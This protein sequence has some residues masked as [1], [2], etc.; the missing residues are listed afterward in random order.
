MMKEVDIFQMALGLTPPWEVASCEFSAE[1]KRLDI[2]L[3]FPRGSVFACPECGR[4]D[5][6]A[7]DTVEKTWRHLNFFQHEAWLSA[8]VPRSRCGQCGVRL[9]SVPWA[10]SGSGFTLLFE[11]LVMSMA[12]TLPV[13]TLA[14]NIGEQDTR[15]WRMIHHYVE[16]ARVRQSHADVSSFGVDETACRRGHKYVSVFMD[17]VT[18][19]VLFVTEG[20]DASTVARFREA[21]EAHGGDAERIAEVCC[22]MSPAFVAGVESAFPKAHLTFDRFH[23]MKVQNE[24]VD[25]VRR[26]E[27]K[28][29]P[30]L[31]GSRY[32]WL[33]NPENLRQEQQ[34]RLAAL[35]LPRQNLKTA[36]AWH[37][38][39]NFQELFRQA[40]EEAE[41]F[42]K[43]WYFWATHSRLEPMKRA[44]ATI[45]SHWAGILRWF[46]SK[47]TGGLL[48]GMNSLIQAAKSRVRGYRT[49]RNLAAMIYLL[50]AK[51]NFSLPT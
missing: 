25:E 26:E 42:L 18:R 43:R 21:F 45:K 33:K 22:D 2:R 3:A 20:K 51:L 49:P 37:L 35:S 41:V 11:A 29:R 47:L 50:G 4:T 5:L 48:E 9:V 12:R 30:E 44:A 40:P 34:A 23:L 19:K 16:E 13:K 27:S 7:H 6:K 36:R 24:A 46:S 38:K 15:L 32:A 8:K 14:A 31:R 1:K 39:L 17:M 28:T 10:R